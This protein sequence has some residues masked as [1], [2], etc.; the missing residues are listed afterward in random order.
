M[1]PHPAAQAPTQCQALRRMHKGKG[2]GPKWEAE[3]LELGHEGVELGLRNNEE[4]GLS[5]T[6]SFACRE[7]DAEIQAQGMQGWLSG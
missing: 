2:M 4:S 6:I 3:T 1:Q 7:V 5:R